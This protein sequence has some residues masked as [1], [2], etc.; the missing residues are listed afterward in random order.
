MEEDEE[1]VEEKKKKVVEGMDGKMKEGE[2]EKD[3]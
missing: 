2:E 3:N 1:A